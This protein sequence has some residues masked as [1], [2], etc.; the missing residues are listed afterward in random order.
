MSSSN[1][2]NETKAINLRQRMENSFEFARRNK[3]PKGDS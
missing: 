3:Y 1:E 2:R